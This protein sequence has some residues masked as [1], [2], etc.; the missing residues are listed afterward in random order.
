TRRLEVVEGDAIETLR[1]KPN[2]SAV[3]I[4]SMHVT[5]YLAFDRVI[6]LL[7]E[8]RRVIRPGG[9]IIIET[10]NSEN[11]HVGSDWSGLHPNRRNPLPPEAFRWIV[12]ARGFEDVRIERLKTARERSAPEPVSK[13]VPGA[14]AINALLASMSASMDYAIIGRRP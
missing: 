4:T 3:A 1:E 2:G 11:L 7:D 10:L 5:E 14:E 12:E 9:L 6:A 13:D 8:A